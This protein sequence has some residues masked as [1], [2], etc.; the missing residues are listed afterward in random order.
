MLKTLLSLS[1]FEFY[2]GSN[3]G[4]RQYVKFENGEL[5]YSFSE[6]LLDDN[7]KKCIPSGAKIDKFLN[8]V[9]KIK[10]AK[11]LYN[12]VTVLDGIEWH[13]KLNAKEFKRDVAG[14]HCWPGELMQ[15]RDALNK[16][17]GRKFLKFKAEDE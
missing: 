14:L 8:D 3:F 7:F 4:D 17:I 12:K 15:L 5:R 11:S 2:Y 6:N 16:L 9:E 13:F 1:S 10:F